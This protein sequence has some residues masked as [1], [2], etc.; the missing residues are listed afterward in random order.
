[1]PSSGELVVDPAR[2]APV[3]RADRGRRGQ[4]PRRV[5]GRRDRRVGRLLPRLR[6]LAVDPARRV[7]EHQDRDGG[8]GGQRGRPARGSRAGGCARRAA[9]RPRGSRRPARPRS[10]RRRAAATAR[11]APGRRRRAAPAPPGRRSGPSCANAHATIGSVADSTPPSATIARSRSGTTRARRRAPMPGRQQRAARV[12]EQQADDQQ[13]E[14]RPRERVQ[15]RVAGA[16]RG[17]PEQRRNPERRRQADAVPVVERR[18]QARERLV[19]RERAPGR[20][21]SA[22]PSRRSGPPTARCA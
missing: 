10:A 8:N 20:P 4:P 3:A 18:P 15:R 11:R 12:R 7:R 1:M 17:E 9:G 13:P 21:W 6:E 22:A 14:R 16:A 19:R 5:V 2:L